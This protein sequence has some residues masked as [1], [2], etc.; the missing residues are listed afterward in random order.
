VSCV[1][2]LARDLVCVNNIASKFRLT[3][4][5]RTRTMPPL[6]M[7]PIG[8]PLKCQ[9]YN[10]LCSVNICCQ[11]QCRY[12]PGGELTAVCMHHALHSSASPLTWSPT[13]GGEGDGEMRGQWPSTLKYSIQSPLL[14]R[15]E[16][17]L[18]ISWLKRRKTSTV[19][20]QLQNAK[21]SETALV[22]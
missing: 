8:W 12:K 10:W 5:S 7:H 16:W 11:L 3:Q 13:V 15:P 17:Q 22:T 21:D 6:R 4:T 14:R 9:Q 20:S 2:E 1:A 18:N 19:Y